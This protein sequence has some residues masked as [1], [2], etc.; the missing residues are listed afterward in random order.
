METC[1]EYTDDGIM[2]VSSDQ[3]RIISRIMKLKKQYPDDV[4]IKK[5]PA[6]NDGCIYA[7]VPAGWLRIAPPRTVNMTDEQRLMS[8]ERMKAMNKEQSESEQDRDV[9]HVTT[10]SVDG[11]MEIY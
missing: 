8:S 1:C 6:D 11:D 2:W 3:R 10:L 5:T 9:V 4:S 7:T